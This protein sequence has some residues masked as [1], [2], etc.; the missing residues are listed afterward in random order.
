M[1]QTEAASLSA[2]QDVSP[3]AFDEHGQE[4]QNALTEGLQMK[5][6][7]S[8]PDEPLE[9]EAD[10]AAAEVSGSQPQG[11][12]VSG[13]QRP[14]TSGGD[15]PGSLGSH[16]ASPS[17]GQPMSDSLRSDMETSFGTD[18]STVRVH[19]SPQDRADADGLGAQA[20]TYRNDIWLGTMASADDRNLMAHELAHV[21]QQGSD[22]RDSHDGENPSTTS[23][24]A[25][26]D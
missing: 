26:D 13:N 24:G 9:R 3:S 5:L 14:V 16:I 4:T 22:A 21:V 1:H 18:F 23:G 17:F 6:T 11:A 25:P 12:V 8:A 7:V 10:R 15:M 19:D 20:F 2:V